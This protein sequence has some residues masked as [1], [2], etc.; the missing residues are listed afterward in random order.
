MPEPS[1]TRPVTAAQVRSYLAKAEEFLAAASAE[2]EAGRSIATM[3]LAIHAAMNAADAVTGARTGRRSAGQR[4]DEVRSLV[5]DSGKDGTEL[6]K[7]LARLLPM[8]T[9]TEYEP[10]AVPTSEAKRAVERA[11]RCVAIARRAVMT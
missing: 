6:E 5:R 11:H 3:S 2:L 9:K 4:H 8:K 7:D 1:R 10:E